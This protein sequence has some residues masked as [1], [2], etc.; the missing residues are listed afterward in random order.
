M[1][2]KTHKKYKYKFILEILLKYDF[3]LSSYHVVSNFD[4]HIQ[5]YSLIIVLS[6]YYQTDA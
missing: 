2:S 3:T 1:L 6:Q 5:I 4:I